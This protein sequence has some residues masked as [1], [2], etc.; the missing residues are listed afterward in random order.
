MEVW[1]FCR[2]ACALQL[3]PGARV[4][5]V[6]AWRARGGVFSQCCAGARARRSPPL[7]VRRAS[8]G[9]PRKCCAHH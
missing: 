4:F 5:E 7:P 2:Q 1:H 8:G 3:C 6:S 9:L